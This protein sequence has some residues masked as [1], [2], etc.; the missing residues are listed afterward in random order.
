MSSRN[1]ITDDVRVAM[2]T[3]RLAEC[4][5]HKAVA[6]RSIV[7]CNPHAQEAERSQLR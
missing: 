6:L 4:F 5:L 1:T 7:L 2:R 3:S